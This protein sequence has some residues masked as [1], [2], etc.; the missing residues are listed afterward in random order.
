MAEEAE[1]RRRSG[2][3]SEPEEDG[4]GEE[5][6]DASGIEGMDNAAKDDTARLKRG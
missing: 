1:L 2:L 3:C 4:L 6:G 5:P